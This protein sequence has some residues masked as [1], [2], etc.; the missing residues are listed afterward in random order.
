M[1]LKSPLQELAGLRGSQLFRMT[2]LG[3]LWTESFS[4]LH[5][6]ET[7]SVVVGESEGKSV[8][9]PSSS[10]DAEKCACDCD[11]RVI[12]RG[13]LRLSTVLRAGFGRTIVFWPWS[14]AI[15]GVDLRRCMKG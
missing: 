8:R 5:A 10:E 9:E 6:G 7:P 3:D 15:V 2:Q 13:Q 12:H 14:T 11:Q 1:F 4:Q